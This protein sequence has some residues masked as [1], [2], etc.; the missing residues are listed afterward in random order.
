MIVSSNILVASS[1]MSRCLMLNDSNHLGSSANF[2][3]GSYL[4]LRRSSPGPELVG[5]KSVYLKLDYLIAE[6]LSYCCISML[7]EEI[8]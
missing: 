2:M 7:K 8:K 4:N 5:S 3:G 1:M 6:R